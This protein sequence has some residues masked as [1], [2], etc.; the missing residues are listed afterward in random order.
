MP[1]VKPPDIPFAKLGRLLRGYGLNE[2]ELS[3]V[4]GCCWRTAQSRLKNPG[5][6]TLAELAKISRQAHIPMGEIRDAISL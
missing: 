4:L 3:E 1:F 6:F 2:R 5:E